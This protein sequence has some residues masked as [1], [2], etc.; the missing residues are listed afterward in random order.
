MDKVFDNPGIKEE[1]CAVASKSEA[2]RAL[3][4]AALS[5]GVTFVECHQTND[6]IDATV[7]CLGALGAKIRQ[8]GNG[9]LV[10]PIKSVNRGAVLECNESG[11][12]LRF[13]LPVASALGADCRFFMK[14]RLPQRPLSPLYELLVE[15]GVSLGE[16]GQNPLCVSGKLSSGK[17]SIAANVSSQ[18]ISGLLMA[19]SVCDGKSTLALTGKTE[20]AP[21]I[22]M[23]VD[24]LNEFGADI[25]FDINKNTFYI[26]GKSRLT[27]PKIARVGG[28]WSGG[29]FF[30]CA[31]AIGKSA[32]TVKGLNT[33]SRQGD[34]HILSVL[35]DMGA[36]IDVTDNGITVHPSKLHGVNID[37]AQIPDLVPILATVA[38]VAEGKTV[39]YN[40]ARLRL[41]E[42]DRIESTCDFL[43][44]LGA[45][46]TPTDDGMIINGKA[47]LVGG[48]VDSFRDHRIAMSAAIASLVCKNSVTVQGFEAIAKSYPSFVENFN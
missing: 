36:K 14:G 15:N 6:D 12:T 45:D 22:D 26:D 31:G 34:K 7:S 21:Y 4:C 5:D 3:I 9:F 8:D 40:A 19:L 38:S 44:H 16:M 1:I 47:E 2:H 39:I 29:A 32:V 24:T 33:S 18:Y 13:L 41:K 35:A 10:E 28:D 43:S 42:S 37:A 48:V 46:I 11:S 27:S 17:F 30:L 23:T 20:S 25:Q